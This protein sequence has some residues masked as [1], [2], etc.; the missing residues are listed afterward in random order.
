MA[1]DF[2]QRQEEARKSTA[3][4]V[5]MFIIAVVMIVGAVVGITAAIIESQLLRSNRPLGSARYTIPA[6]AGL[7]AFLIIAAGSLFKVWELRHGGGTKVAKV[8]VVGGS[9]RTRMIIS[10][11]D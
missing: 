6:A 11:D 3:F 4:L 5:V 10:N 1:T 8:W 9:T 7:M 2:Y